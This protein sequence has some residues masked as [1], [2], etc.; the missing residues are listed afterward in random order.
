M[1][2]ASIYEINYREGYPPSSYI[3]G[4]VVVDRRAERRALVDLGLCLIKAH[5]EKHSPRPL[6]R[7]QTDTLKGVLVEEVC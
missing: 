5:H 2:I 6:W 7:R 1:T 3:K 4:E